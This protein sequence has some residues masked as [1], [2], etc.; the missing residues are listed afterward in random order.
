M[1]A[2]HAFAILGLLAVIAGGCESPEYYNEHRAANGLVIVLPGI[3][4]IDDASYNIQNALAR[5]GVN[6]AIVLQPWGKQVPLAGLLLNQMDPLGA[7]IEA[8]AIA[9]RITRYQERYPAAPVHIVGHSGGGAIAVFVA[10]R[11]AFMDS[12]GQGAGPIDGIVLLSPSISS[13]YDLTNVLRFCKKGVVNCYNPDDVA[14]EGVGTTVFGNLDGVRG[15]SA[16]LNGF[17]DPII[18]LDDQAEVDDLYARKLF[19]VIVPSGYDAHFSSTNPTF[20]RNQPAQWILTG[21]LRP[22]DR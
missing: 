2:R 19:Q 18:F 20:I 6:H 15:P 5:A 14:V 9:D 11:L 4:G 21:R 8:M 22:D 1:T 3:Q 16:G 13:I 7:R 12:Q 10:D 17:D